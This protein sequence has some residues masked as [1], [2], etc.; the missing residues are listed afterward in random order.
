MILRDCFRPFKKNSYYAQNEG[1]GSLFGPKS[2]FLEI[3]S[4]AVHWPKKGNW[5]NFGGQNQ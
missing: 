3:F 1:S 5:G 4:L 2:F